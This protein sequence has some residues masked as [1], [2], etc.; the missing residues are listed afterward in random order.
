MKTGVIGNK[1]QTKNRNNSKLLTSRYIHIFNVT[2]SREIV[3][4][5]KTNPH[6]KM[7]MKAKMNILKCKLIFPILALQSKRYALFVE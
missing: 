5:R 4:R 3:V 6:L 2:L 1:K 7:K